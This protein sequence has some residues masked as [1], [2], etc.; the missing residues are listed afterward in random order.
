MT[1]G[2]L[3]RVVLAI[4]ACCF[5]CQAATKIMR[6]C[7]GGKKVQTTTTKTMKDIL[8][9]AIASAG[10]LHPG[11]CRAML[12]VNP[13]IPTPNIALA[14]LTEATFDGYTRKNLTWDAVGNGPNGVAQTLVQL[15]AP[16][17]CTGP[18]AS[19]TIYGMAVVSDPLGIGIFA[20]NIVLPF[21]DS[22]GVAAPV[23]VEKADDQVVPPTPPFFFLMGG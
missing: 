5:G 15:A 6:H 4:K 23:T 7:R 17:I 3:M 16:W 18:T 21:V 22:A 8:G 20:L 1:S 2:Y 14:D 19:N 9:A 13:I 11:D 12:Y 10:P